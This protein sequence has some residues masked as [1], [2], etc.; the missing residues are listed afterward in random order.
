MEVRPRYALWKYDDEALPEDDLDLEDNLELMDTLSKEMGIEDIVRGDEFE[1]I[2]RYWESIPAEQ[3]HGPCLK[4]EIEDIVREDEFERIWRYLESIPAEQ[5]HGPCLK[6]EIE[7]IVREDEF[8][9]IWRY[10]ESIPADYRPM[11][12]SNVSYRK[13]TPEEKE[14]F[15]ELLRKD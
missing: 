9:R 11:L 10:L 8:E 5:R 6:K 7:D 1:R 14:R 13:L 15:I 12:E 4:K 3:R 2:C